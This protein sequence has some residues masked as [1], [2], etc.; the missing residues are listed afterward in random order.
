[1]T[2]NIPC[3]NCGCQY[4][5]AETKL[6]NRVKIEICR[7]NDGSGEFTVSIIPQNNDE[8]FYEKHRCSQEEVANCLTAR[9]NI[10]LSTMN[11]QCFN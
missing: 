2:I 1:M 11:H 6:G 4:C 5:D 7:C 9:F 8:I 10:D 3:P